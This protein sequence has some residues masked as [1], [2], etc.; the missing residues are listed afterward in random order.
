MA[1]QMRTA[2]PFQESLL[3]GMT[4]GVILSLMPLSQVFKDRI[5]VAEAVEVWGAWLPLCVVGVTVVGYLFR[6]FVL[7]R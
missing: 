7:D 6:K 1:K 5:T 3:I 4:S 2:R